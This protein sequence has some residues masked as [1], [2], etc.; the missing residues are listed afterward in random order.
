VLERIK[1]GWELGRHSLMVVLYDKT[2]MWFPLIATLSVLFTV[3]MF[4]M[5]VGPD[6]VR[7]IFSTLTNDQGVQIINWGY[8]ET[9]L[10][11]YFTLSFVV[12]FCN[13]ALVGCADISIGERDSKFRD[14]V[15]V[16]LRKIHYVLIWSIVSCIFS[17]IF[18]LLEQHRFT[19]RGVR[20]IFGADWSL[21]T[22]FVIPVMVVERTNIFSALR[23]SVKL[24]TETWGEHVV[25]RTGIAWFWLFFLLPAGI[26][27]GIVAWN[28][29]EYRP[30]MTAL[31]LTYFALT[32]ILF[33]TIKS[34]L[35]VVLYRY[36]TERVIPD[37]F[38]RETLQDAITLR[39][40]DRV[41]TEVD[42]SA[43]TEAP[44]E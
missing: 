21:I 18:L 19:S 16:G 3:W 33:Q 4:Y 7:F 43:D 25:A 2:L 35:T 9:V 36:A 42:G 29:P 12:V 28:A 31:G 5:S 14:G 22:Y 41:A 24:M 37:R 6:K 23:R 27:A 30:L 26:A 38:N 15:T 13:V 34:V 11:A 20:A 1:R 17:P 32:L 8:Y 39:K 44:A 10:I 40:R